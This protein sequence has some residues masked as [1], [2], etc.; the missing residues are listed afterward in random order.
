MSG[1]RHVHLDLA[2]QAAE[3][4]GDGRDDVQQELL[5]HDVQQFN[6]FRYHVQ[7][8]AAPIRLEWGRVGSEGGRRMAANDVRQ[9]H[10][11][12]TL[13]AAGVTSNR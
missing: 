6:S 12:L 8:A 5:P 7:G 1:W 10:A 3:E 13:R 2:K 11:T 4:A 9:G